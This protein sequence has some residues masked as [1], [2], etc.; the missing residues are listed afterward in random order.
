MP[1]S[2]QLSFRASGYRVLLDLLPRAYN[3]GM[4]LHRILTLTA[5]AM[6]ALSVFFV[7]RPQQTDTAVSGHT[8]D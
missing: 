3:G 5:S 1:G 2:E 8:G 4:R 7:L 6:L